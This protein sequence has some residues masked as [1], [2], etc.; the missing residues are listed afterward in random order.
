M[1]LEFSFFFEMLLERIEREEQF[2]PKLMSFLCCTV[3][4]SQGF[5]AQPRSLKRS[6]GI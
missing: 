4:P 1:M 5:F 3:L 2:N 6:L